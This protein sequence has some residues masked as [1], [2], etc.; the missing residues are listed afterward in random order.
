MIKKQCYEGRLKEQ[1]FHIVCMQ[2]FGAQ[3]IL[4]I[5][6]KQ[7]RKHNE[8]IAIGSQV[9]Q[10]QHQKKEKNKKIHSYGTLH[11]RRFFLF[12]DAKIN[13][14]NIELYITDEISLHKLRGLQN[15]KVVFY[16]G[17]PQIRNFRHKILIL[18]Q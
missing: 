14:A 1:Q 8:I 11:E 2:N 18:G 10:I 15:R 17:C 6:V 4:R 16:R 9:K 12:I 13:Q 3:D 5:T 7:E